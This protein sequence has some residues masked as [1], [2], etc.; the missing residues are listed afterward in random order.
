M[1]T[2]TGWGVDPMYSH[3]FLPNQVY[4]DPSNLILQKNSRLTHTNSLHGPSQGLD[5]STLERLKNPHWPFPPTSNCETSN[6]WSLKKRRKSPS[7]LGGKVKNSLLVELRIHG[8]S[9]AVC[10]ENTYCI[11]R[12]LIL[13]NMNMID[14][15]CNYS[16]LK[17]NVA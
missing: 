14:C 3:V 10:I 6:P 16:I 4:V 17:L 8:I 15:T 2:V 1:V 9:Q 13:Y 5:D 11:C 7:F 12:W